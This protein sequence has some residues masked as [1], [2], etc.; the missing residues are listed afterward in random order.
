MRRFAAQI[1]RKLESWYLDFENAIMALLT[2][3]LVLM[4]AF[5]TAHLCISVVELIIGNQLDPRDPG[6]YPQIFSLIFTILIGFEFKHS[7]LNAT[8]TQT[9]VVR[10]RSIILIGMLATVRR[11]IIL[12]LT[13]TNVPDTLAA[14]ACV[15]AL[16]IVYWLVRPGAPPLDPGW[17]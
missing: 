15:L 8:A 11:I 10:I 14:A 1:A 2:V 4:V 17:G 6:L 5:A 7:F 3:L 16:G 12:D 13:R 9:S